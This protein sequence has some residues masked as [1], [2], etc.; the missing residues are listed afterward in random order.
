MSPSS[1]PQSPDRPRRK[2]QH[3]R[4]TGFRATIACHR[5]ALLGRQAEALDEAD[6]DRAFF[7]NQFLE[8]FVPDGG[9][10]DTEGVEQFA[11][12]LAFSAFDHQVRYAL[13]HL[14]RQ[15]GGPTRQMKPW[16]WKALEVT[17]CSR[18]VATSGSLLMRFFC[19]TAIGRPAP[20]CRTLE[21][22]A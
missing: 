14:L 20:D 18:K 4:T 17:P 12:A 2:H 6:P 21:A 22:A 8:V 9:V 3:V 13:D 10:V 7:G 16:S 5:L 1:R 19:G 11:H 15:T